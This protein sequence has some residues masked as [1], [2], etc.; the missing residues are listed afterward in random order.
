VAA[1]IDIFE[2]H[3]RSF[4]V[5][6]D[7][8][9]DGRITNMEF[10]GNNTTKQM[11]VPVGYVC[12]D[13]LMAITWGKPVSEPECAADG[14]GACLNYGYYFRPDDYTNCWKTECDLRPW[15]KVVQ[16]NWRKQFLAHRLRFFN[17]Y[18]VMNIEEFKDLE[19]PKVSKNSQVT[20]RK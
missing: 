8:L 18:N 9:S 7:C 20:T 3:S 17:P 4:P 2:L 16:R 10:D 15:V 5:L 19:T 6:I 13:M 14:L 12:L 11:K 1:V